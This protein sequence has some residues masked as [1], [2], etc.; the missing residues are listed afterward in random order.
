MKDMDGTGLE[1]EAERET[2]F[3]SLGGI[4]YPEALDPYLEYFNRE[5]KSN[6]W[7]MAVIKAYCLGMINGKK[8][9]RRE[10]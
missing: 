5:A 4:E 7:P 10:T 3:K 2:L 8:E 1:N 6:G 9:I